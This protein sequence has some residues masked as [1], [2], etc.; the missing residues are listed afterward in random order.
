MAA[1]KR[2]RHGHW[3][4]LPGGRRV[5]TREWRIWSNIKSRCYNPNTPAYHY[6][7]GRGIVMCDEWRYSF[8]AFYRDVGDSPSA[9]HSIDRIDNDGPYAPWNVKWATASEQA[10]NRRP[11]RYFK[12]TREQAMEIRRRVACGEP[13]SSLAA[14]FGVTSQNV[15]DIYNNKLWR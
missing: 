8:T 14:E 10:M 3:K 6:Y 5:P 11:R 7:G 12:L 1:S 4:T 2:E 9:S 15:G 13:R